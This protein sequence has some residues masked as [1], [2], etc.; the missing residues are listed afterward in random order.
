[1][2]ASRSPDGDCFDIHSIEGLL[3]AAE[4][5]TRSAGILPRSPRALR[6]QA[7]RRPRYWV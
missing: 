3:P 5:A 2:L 6:L 7:G 4:A 1:M